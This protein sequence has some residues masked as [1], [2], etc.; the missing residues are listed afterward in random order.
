MSVQN[1]QGIGKF[2][3]ETLHEISQNKFGIQLENL[4]CTS[5][6]KEHKRF[7]INQRLRFGFHDII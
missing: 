7:R 5:R 3:S 6:V 1:V 2:S 4:C